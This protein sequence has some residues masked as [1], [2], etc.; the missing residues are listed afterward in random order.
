[1][2]R[3]VTNNVGLNYAKETVAGTID[4]A[5]QW[6]QTEPNAINT[7]G[8]TISTVSREP[9]SKRKQ[10]QKGT[11]SDLN[12]SVEFTQ[13]LTIEPFADFVEG[14]TFSTFNGT[15]EFKPT[16]VTAGGAGSGATFDITSAG[17][18]PY[19]VATA[20]VSAGGTGY[21][22]GDK[23]EVAGTGTKAVLTVATL[24]GSAVATVTITSAG[25]Y[26][27]DPAGLGIATT[28]ASGGYTVASGGALAAN[29]LVYA[30]GFAV[31]ANNGIK[32]VL[33]NSIATNIHITGLTAETVA[34]T[35]NATLAIAGRKAATGDLSI[36]SGG[37]LASVVLDFTTLGLTVGQSIW[38]GGSTAGSKFATAAD[39]GYARIT[40][41]AAN[42]LSLDKTSLTFTVDA[43]T[44]KDIELYFGRFAR[45]VSVDDADYKE[46]AY[47]FELAMPD[48]SAVGVPMYEYAKGNYCNS[49]Q[50][51]LPLTDKA[52]L[53]LGFIGM[54]TDLPTTT[55]NSTAANALAPTQ[56]VAFGTSSD[57]ARLRLQKYD[58]TGLSTYFKNLSVTLMNNVSPEKALATLGAVFMNAGNFDVNVTAELI[59][60]NSAVVDAIRNN[61]TV[62]MD[63]SIKNDDGAILVDIPSMTLGGGAKNLTMNESVKIALTGQAFEDA[64]LGTSIGV[65]LFPYIPA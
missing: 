33:S 20:V 21:I 26:S 60:T 57:I 17:A 58:E 14:F 54:D 52:S 38:I 12:S 53:Q 18:G 37:D 64:I 43:G 4:A 24:S 30:R 61:E 2:S 9:I 31:A 62:T 10:R 39:T 42:L 59:F 40:A 13:D 15:S 7:Y 3:V 45:N 51:T 8:S 56:K 11:I 16:A 50:F 1:M 5:P 35:R 44:G 48:L 29:T 41:I 49:M 25:S 22:V 28:P 63:F 34:S 36:T 65:S 46:Q 19:T 27:V 32:T 47:T 55:R 23:L 6:K